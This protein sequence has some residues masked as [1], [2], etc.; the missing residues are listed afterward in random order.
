[1]SRRWSLFGT[2]CL[3]VGEKFESVEDDAVSLEL[4]EQFE[5]AVQGH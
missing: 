2:L 5:S 3:S 4:C 1:M